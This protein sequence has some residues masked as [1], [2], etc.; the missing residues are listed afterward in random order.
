M[1]DSQGN[2]LPGVNIVVKG[3]TIGTTTDM[4]GNYSIEV[5][6]PNS[7]LVFSY[8]GYLS[9]EVSLQGR[10]SINISLAEDVKNLEEVVV[11]GYG[12][13]KKR[14]VTSAVASVKEEDFNKG[15]IVSSP[16]QLVQGKVAGLAISR[17]N[18]GDPNSGVQMQLRG[19]STVRGT[20]DLS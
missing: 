15:A 2:A 10:A 18:G 20:A 8:V 3:T 12:T 9:Q 7:T 5:T 19:V 4:D 16:L 6:D 14:E 1:T 17:N 11:V 13:Q